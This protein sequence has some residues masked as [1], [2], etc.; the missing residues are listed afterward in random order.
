MRL[1]KIILTATTIKA[2]CF[3]YLQEDRLMDKTQSPLRQLLMPRCKGNQSMRVLLTE[4]D[5]W[6]SF[7]AKTVMARVKTAT[8]FSADF[9]IFS[10]RILLHKKTKRYQDKVAELSNRLTT[11]STPEPLV[12]RNTHKEREYLLIISKA[13][14]L[15]HLTIATTITQSHRVVALMV[16]KEDHPKMQV[17]VKTVVFSSR[18]LSH[19]E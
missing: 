15:F 2:I 7:K 19:Q 10:Y 1:N 17:K 16:S 18:I 14:K 5:K 6:E 12:L 3:H 4:M 8:K 11:F 9:Q 13:M